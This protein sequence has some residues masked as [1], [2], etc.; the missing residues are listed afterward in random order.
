VVVGAGSVV[1]AAVVVVGLARSPCPVLAPP[2][3]AVI[4][5]ASTT[6]PRQERRQRFTAFEAIG[7]DDPQGIGGG[8]AH[9]GGCAL[10]RAPRENLVSAFLAE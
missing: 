7:R 5:I 1:G 8:A 6:R 4:A 2:P 10:F 9:G 3:Q